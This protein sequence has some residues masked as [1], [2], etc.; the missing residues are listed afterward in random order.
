MKL[1]SF[2]RLV[3]LDLVI[4]KLGMILKAMSRHPDF[5]A[6]IM[7][8]LTHTSINVLVIFN[9]TSIKTS[10]QCLLITRIVDVTFL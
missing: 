4:N 6:L 3:L 7:E 10:C 2:I 8:K 9:Y 1:V 5:V